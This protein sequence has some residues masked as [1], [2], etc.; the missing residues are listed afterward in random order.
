MLICTEDSSKI[1]EASI[2]S[3]N[4]RK[5]LQVLSLCHTV[6]VEQNSTQKKGQPQDESESLNLLHDT[7]SEEDSASQ[8]TYQAAS[9]DEE[10]LVKVPVFPPRSEK[11]VIFSRVQGNLDLFSPDEK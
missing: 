2:H 4:V 5:L 3:E 7:I 11:R 1:S 10:A 9:P 6:V 8:I